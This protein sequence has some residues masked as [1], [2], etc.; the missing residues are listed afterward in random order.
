MSDVF[1]LDIENRGIK[2]MNS[3]ITT[4]K[5]FKAKQYVTTDII[6]AVTVAATTIY[7]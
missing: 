5:G 3:I 1:V 4:T 7:K 6:V 2:M